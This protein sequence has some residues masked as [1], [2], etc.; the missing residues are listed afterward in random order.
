MTVVAAID[1]GTNSVH[2][3]VASF[4]PSGHF[5]VLTREKEQVR[6]GSGADDMKILDPDAIERG[7]AALD[8]MR[9][10]ATHSGADGVK[11]VA[12]SAVREAANRDEFVRRAR[13]EAGIVVDVISGREEARLIHLG[14]LQSAAV[15]GTRHLVVDIGGGST[16]FVIGEGPMP[17]LLR[18]LKLGAIRLTDRFFPAGRVEPGTLDACA[19]HVDSFLV[20]VDRDIAALGFETAVGSSGTI[21]T[22]ADMTRPASDDTRRVGTRS[23]ARRD[24]EHLLDEFARRPSVEERADMHGL[25]ARRADII[26]AGA[27]LLHRVMLRL[28]VDHLTVS[29]FALREGVLFE[30]RRRASA[31]GLDP[32]HRLGD[33]RRSSVMHTAGRYHEDLSH[34][35]HITD[36]ALEIFD[37]TAAVHGLDEEERD[38]LEAA[39]LMHNVGVYVAHAAHHQHSYYLIRNAEHLAGFTEREVEL[40]ALVARYHRKSAPKAKHPEFAQLDPADQHRVR[41]MAAILRIAIGLD[42]SNRQVV[43]GAT[44]TVDDSGLHIAAQVAHGDDA[45][46]ELF[47]A[48]ARSGLLSQLVDGEVVVSITPSNPGGRRTHPTM[49]DLGGRAP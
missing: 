37:D 48:Q 17:L 4:D 16:E 27:V 2:L 9:R 30:Q 38:L 34:A 35:E 45:S 7:I 6:L 14:V 43:H 33:L 19:H 23:V 12:T 28:G 29:E 46:L 40:M 15:F 24:L 32:F 11:A 36:L 21:E 39:G 42:R 5:E 44:A 49:G 47:S 20:G 10:I 18:S 26:V 8:R 3:V 41:W 31:P 22:L 1:I 13:Q 25:E